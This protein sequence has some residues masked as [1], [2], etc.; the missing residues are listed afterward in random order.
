MEKGSRRVFL[1]RGFLEDMVV[2]E[3]THLRK[4]VA[5]RSANERVEQ[6]GLKVYMQRRS[7]SKFKVQSV[8]FCGRFRTNK[9]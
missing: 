8:T 3:L 6:L 4:L 9:F 7:D 5:T 1:N 2:R